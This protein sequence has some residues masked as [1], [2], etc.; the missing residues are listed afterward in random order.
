MILIGAI[1]E[2]NYQAWILIVQ[3]TE[4]IFNTCR[5]GWTS[6]SVEIL[7]ML[8]WRHNVLT[9]ESEGFQQCTISLHNLLHLVDDIKCFASPNNYRCYVFERAV[10]KYVIQSSYNKNLELTFAQAEIRRELLKF[11]ASSE[12]SHNQV[13]DMDL[14]VCHLVLPYNNY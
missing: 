9:E 6:N 3:I 13:I 2:E 11:K 12:H 1:P 10:H 8:I 4:L 14:E 5:S 7:R